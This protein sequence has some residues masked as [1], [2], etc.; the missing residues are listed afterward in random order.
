MGY[1]DELE[2]QL[3]LVRPNAVADRL[4]LVI[5]SSRDWPSDTC[6]QVTHALFSSI[7][8]AYG[9]YVRLAHGDAVGGD[10]IAKHIGND[11]RW[12]VKPYPVSDAEWL[13]FGG[14]AG[15]QRNARMLEAEQPDLVIALIHNRSRGATGCRD[16][17]LARGIPT[18]TVDDELALLRRIRAM[19]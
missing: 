18:V 10:Q 8:S 3:Q 7:R 5:T 6:T 4:R 17:A 12:T 19:M 1:L 13:A 9:R 16:N 11:F 15:H 2:Y 14:Y